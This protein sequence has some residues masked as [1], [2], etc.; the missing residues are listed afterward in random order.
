MV[1]AVEL[2]LR[3]RIAETQSGA[4]VPQGYV[5]CSQRCVV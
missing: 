1:E 2:H 3:D 5:A 4:D